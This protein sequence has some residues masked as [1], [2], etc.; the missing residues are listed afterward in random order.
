MSR[1]QTHLT[2]LTSL[3]FLTL[4]LLTN[5]Q[6]KNEQSIRNI[7]SSQIIQWNKGN[8][9]GF[10]KGYWESDSLL[11]VGKMGAKYGYQTTLANYKKNYP[12]TIAMGKLSYDILKLQQLA[13][14]CYFVLGKFMLLRT[15]GNLSGYYTLLF[16][17][18]NQ[19]WVIVADHSS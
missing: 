12:D 6:N 16:R 17:K 8:I 1:R 9:D 11:F 3:T 13:P 10:M 18:L 14:D 19:K 5:A 7:L 2:L 4:S 15:I